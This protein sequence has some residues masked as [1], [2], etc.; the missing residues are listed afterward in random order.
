MGIVRREVK[1]VATAY[2]IDM[3]EVGLEV[4]LELEY[5]PPYVEYIV[6]CVFSGTILKRQSVDWNAIIVCVFRQVGIRFRRNDDKFV[7]ALL[8]GWQQLCCKN[9]DAADGGPKSGRPK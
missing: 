7:A 5:L 4:L 1:K 8:Q 6:D 9:V 3:D 2:R